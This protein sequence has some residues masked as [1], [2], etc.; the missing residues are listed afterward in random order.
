MHSTGL[1]LG[2][3]CGLFSSCKRPSWLPQ[4]SAL[5]YTVNLLLFGLALGYLDKK[6]GTGGLGY[7]SHSIQS[8]RDLDPHVVL[9][10]FLP[11][12]IYESASSI[13]YHTFRKLLKQ[14]VILAV[15]GTLISTVLI[16]LIVNSPFGL[17]YDFNWIEATVLGTML[18]ATDPVA[19]VALLKELGAPEELGTLI[20]SESLLNDG[21]AFALFLVFKDMMMG[22]KEHTV[23]SAIGQIC[24]MSIVGVAIGVAMGFLFVYALGLIWNDAV[25]EVVL[26][27][28]F[29]FA[30]FFVAEAP[31]IHASGVLAVVCCGVVFSAWSKSTLNAEVAK[32]MHETWAILGFIANTLVFVYTGV[33]VP[34]KIPQRNFSRMNARRCCTATD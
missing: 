32:V 13:D 25:V 6:V 24:S 20:E 23:G 19:V 29:A 33:L 18:S 2:L 31:A 1:R 12:L 3:G 16:A 28:T 22:V 8:W 30:V 17:G 27:I 7:L 21:V 4:L 26:A 14:S 11:P 10:M 34:V 5:P 9:Y 15:P